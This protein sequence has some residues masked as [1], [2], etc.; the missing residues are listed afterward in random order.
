MIISELT[1]LQIN[2]TS[3]HFA[4][5]GVFEGVFEGVLEG[6]FEGVEEGFFEGVEL[7]VFEGVG[8]G[9]F[10]GD[11]LAPTLALVEVLPFDDVP[12]EAVAV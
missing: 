8:L 1:N 9:V 10:E 5:E 11:G 6:V 4:L 3:N 7:G 2:K 12:A